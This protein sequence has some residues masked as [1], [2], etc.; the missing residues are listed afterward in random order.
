MMIQ[1]KFVF[2]VT[3]IYQQLDRD[4]LKLYSEYGNVRLHVYHIK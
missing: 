4:T 3:S 2:K 1:L